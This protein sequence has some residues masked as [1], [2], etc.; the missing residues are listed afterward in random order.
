MLIY[1]FLS[2]NGRLESKKGFIISGCTRMSV[3]L[4]ERVSSRHHYQ[5]L[6]LT[7]L[8]RTN[9]ESLILFETVPAANFLHRQPLHCSGNYHSCT[10]GQ[11]PAPAA[12]SSAPAATSPAPAT[13]LQQRLPVLHQQ[14]PVLHQRPPSCSSVYQFCTSS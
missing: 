10:G 9:S 4:G 5:P 12:I 13:F 11:F 3:F 14:L 1:P 2:C 8:F 6:N 7:D